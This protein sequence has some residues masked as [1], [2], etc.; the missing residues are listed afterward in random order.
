MD[1]NVTAVMTSLQQSLSG[2]DNVRRPA[3][4]YLISVETTRNY[5]ILLLQL[6]DKQEV[7]FVI[8]IAAS[9][10][11]K[12]FVKR[13]WVV[14][15]DGNDKIS[16]E[17]RVTVK[18][19]II[20]L[21]L[22]SEEQIQR[23]LSDAVSIIGREDFPDKWPNLL[24]EMIAQM[25]ASLRGGGDFRIINGILQTCHSLFKRYRHEFKSQQLWTE[26]KFV[27]D[28]FAKPFT[29]LFVA[30]VEL[31]K[32]H[33]NNAMASKILY[34]SL[35]LCAK[36][37]S[38]LN[39][40]DLPEFF[41]D[42]MSVWMQNFLD[43]LSVSNKL[44]QTDDEEEAGLLEQ[45]KSQIC[46]NIGMYAQKY[47]DEFAQYLAGFVNAVWSL[48]MSTGIEPKYDILVSSAIKFL[49]TVADRP[50]N[51]SLFQAP[52]VLDSLCSK[53]IIPNMQFRQSDEEMFEDNPEEYIRRDI[54]GSDVDTRRRAACDLVK[55][56]SR[57]FEAQITQVF[58]QYIETMLSSFAS[59]PKEHWKSK[60]AAIYLVTAMSVKGS[61]TRFGTSQ[62]SQLVN[63]VDFYRNFIKSDLENADLTYLPVLRADALK[64][65]MTFRN[66]LPLN[67][68]ILPSLPMVI[69]NL[70]A[71]SVVVH[72]YACHTLERLFTMRDAS[73]KDLPLIK[74]EHI[75]NF[76]TPLV[77]GLFGVLSI[78]GSSENEYAMKAIM[79]MFSLLQENV[80]PFL[81]DVMG[82]MIN[83]LREI[84]KNP[85]KPFFNHYLFESIS[86]CI[87]IA[88][89]SNVQ[90]VQAFESLLFPLFQEILTADVQE[91]MPYVFQVLS[92]MLEANQGGIS[93]LYIQ[94]FP[95]LLT[96][97]LWDRPANIHPLVRLLQAFIE[98]GA[99]QIVSS[100]QLT[101]LLGV[102]QKL[103]AS[104][105]NDHEGF[106]LLQSII[107]HIDASS[108]D[109]YL[110]DIF[111]LLFTRL[112]TSKTTK[113]VKCL[114]VFLSLFAYKYGPQSLVSMIDK[115]QAKMF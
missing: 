24:N 55:S 27:L 104:K 88:C 12:N 36:I 89:R 82:R 15:E 85:S 63:V 77:Q 20:G 62:T 91:F 35:V 65:I 73:Q 49:S 31:S 47:H 75:Q 3:E 100:H 14:D 110:K 74:M 102:F 48:L 71:P 95:F 34:S 115:I 16:A 18:N 98:K 2:D 37:F 56:L 66:Q 60:D 67:D 8:R 57:Y 87:K 99:Q 80:L 54:E 25:E 59:N 114:L 39:A 11:F 23:Q 111:L 108:I 26:I 78:Q 76:V 52:G 5:P 94:L 61:V 96:P 93:D 70:S 81:E 113:F 86:V 1:V 10:T 90:S 64:Y 19:L 45:L 33:A 6:I 32:T 51:E 29:D 83:K 21:M 41:E 44:L 69:Q 92:L 28:T 38:S 112:S 101:P 9:I 106:Y 22:K 4:K 72:T 84:S 105:M 68:V 109:A 13:H 42:N 103:N 40:Q 7:D 17:D 107:E 97:I 43:L 50:Q 46:E 79:R 53:V 30:T 58:S